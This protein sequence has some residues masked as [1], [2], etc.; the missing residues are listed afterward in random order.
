MSFG[1]CMDLGHSLREQSLFEDAEQAFREAIEHQPESLDAWFYLGNVLRYQDR[2]CEA[3]SAYRKA[4]E[5]DRFDPPTWH[6]LGISLADLGDWAGS[7]RAD[8]KSIQ[9][10]PSEEA[11]YCLGLSLIKLEKYSG[12]EAAFREALEHNYNSPLA[13]LFMGDTLRYR[14]LHAR[15]ENEYLKSLDLDSSNPD[16][17]NKLGI[18]LELQGR[19]PEAIEA[20]FEAAARDPEW[21]LPWNN[22]GMSREHE[23]LYP[24]ARGAYQQSITIDC[25]YAPA[26]KNLARIEHYLGSE[27][28]ALEAYRKYLEIEPDDY[29]VWCELADIFY[30]Q[31]NYL[32]AEE[33]YRAAIKIDRKDPTTWFYLSYALRYQGCADKL[34]EAERAARRA[35]NLQPDKS[36]RRAAWR[37]TAAIREEL[38]YDPSQILYAYSKMSV[39]TEFVR[40][41]QPR[42]E[43]RMDQFE[44]PALAL[45]KAA[46]YAVSAGEPHDLTALGFVVQSKGRTLQELLNHDPAQ[47][48]RFL[49]GHEKRRLD[50]LETESRKI[51]AEPDALVGSRE[52]SDPTIE[53][54][55]QRHEWQ[56]NQR[57]L[58][59]DYDDY[60]QEL[61]IYHPELEGFVLRAGPAAR[62]FRFSLPKLQ[63]TLGSG[64]AVLELLNSQ[65][66]LLAFLITKCGLIDSSIRE[67]D[68]RFKNRAS[69]R[70]WR[71]EVIDTLH[72]GE[73]NGAHCPGCL[74]AGGR[75]INIAND[76]TPDVL[77]R[78][79]ELLYGPVIDAL[80][81]IT[82]LYV[83]PH[84]FLTQLPFNAIPFP[85]G[86]PREVV[87]IPSA[88]SLTAPIPRRSTSGPAY[89]LGVVAADGEP[90]SPLYLQP[91][92]VRRLRNTVPSPERRWE[93][94]GSKKGKKGQ[95][96]TLANL[97]KRGG[98]T[99]CLVLS[100]HGQG[101]DENWG[102]LALGSR[103]KPEH[104]TGRQLV[105]TLLLGGRS[106]QMEVD[107]V[108]T[109]ACLTGQVNMERS[110]EWLGLPMAL[111]SIWKTRAM[112]LT[113]WE[114]LELPAM[115]WVTTLVKELTGGVTVG[116]AHERARNRVR[117]TTIGDVQ[118]LWLPDAQENL[119]DNRYSAVSSWW[120][121]FSEPL[122]QASALDPSTTQYPFSHPV[123]WAPFTLIG[124]P[125][126]TISRNTLP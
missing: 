101:P 26:W 117:K 112:L 97:Q 85:D 31:E 1:D 9:Y 69:L 29:R 15:A 124:D 30:R 94:A 93:L 43:A 32:N 100:C 33:A 58:N 27:D 20:Y 105:D 72:I 17:W 34:K 68:K 102:T 24:E 123:Y 53:S 116:E 82:R 86:K 16:A 95:E 65:D 42:W 7:A 61:I 51:E 3:R 57:K 104:V 91:E 122:Q 55:D 19:H 71:D 60:L 92:E 76:L 70:E 80:K 48:R 4:L 41:A 106:Q 12:A 78:W 14:G 18:S 47:L 87:V 89:T 113:L 11:W 62:K 50:R 79:G 54:Q 103:D 64:E 21:C 118:G 67:P 59:L 77:S 125:N 119:P 37:L 23:R 115:I 40:A 22:L 63:K 98:R 6:N 107:V 56:T 114:V 84:S 90:E 83:S 8:R 44:T 10:G 52:T 36:T 49:S 25:S 46:A 35:I 38:G 111:Q 45:Q 39:D 110:E 108:I 74:A 81:D 121:T 73:G 99:G 88:A 96:P 13:W 28:R 120:R 66:R 75:A 109:S 5:R 2:P 126:V